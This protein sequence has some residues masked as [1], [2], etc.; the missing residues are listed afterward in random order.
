MHESDGSPLPKPIAILD[1][2][3]DP[4]APPKVLVQWSNT[5]LEDST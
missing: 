5:F 4:N 2:K 1:W 3:F